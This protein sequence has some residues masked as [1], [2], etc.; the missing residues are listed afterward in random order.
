MKIQI[1]IV[2]A[3]SANNSGGNP[4]GIVFNADQLSNEQ[5]QQIAAKAGFPETAFVSS[6]D[7]ADFKLDFFTP[8][9]QI[10]HCGHATIATFSL[11]KQNGLIPGDRSSKE[12]I[13][14]KREIFFKG[15]LAF[16]EQKASR[17][18]SLERT[19]FLFVL[20]SLGIDAS[21]LIPGLQPMIVNT[22]N[23]FLIIPVKDTKTLAGISMIKEKVNEI[24]AKYAL[25]GYYLFSFDDSADF[26]ATTRM[27]APYYGIDEEAGTGMAAGPLASYLYEIAG[28]KQAV[29]RISQ[30][31]Y[32][33]EPSPSIIMV[34]LEVSS[35]GIQRLFAGGL[36]YLSGQIFVE[37]F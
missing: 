25:I 29:F 13:D 4:A 11:M 23:S 26:D 31:R 3:F 7:T 33:K 30:G 10:P 17:F 2:N 27:F 36:A 21:Y 14:G 12:T 18:S 8:V 1:N 5:K 34:E 37:V 15:E 35:S 9:K 32:M 28:K 19:A 6:S 16:M 22:G 20:E 24:S